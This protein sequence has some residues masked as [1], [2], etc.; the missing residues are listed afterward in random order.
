MAL[1]GTE[2]YQLGDRLFEVDWKKMRNVEGTAIHKD[3]VKVPNNC[4]TE[5]LMEWTHERMLK[6]MVL[7]RMGWSIRYTVSSRCV[8][9]TIPLGELSVSKDLSPLDEK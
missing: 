7:D 5:E 8:A 1:S 3:S 4:S 6:T 9:W 2:R